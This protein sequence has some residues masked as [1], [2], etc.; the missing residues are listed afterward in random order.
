[1]SNSFS[2]SEPGRCESAEWIN[3]AADVCQ[4]AA[5]GNLEERLLHVHQTGNAQR[6]MLSINHLLDMTD[7]FVREATAT[8][9]HASQGKFF[10]RVLKTGMLGTFGRASESINEATAKMDGEHRKL[11]TAETD[12]E[13][14]SS[15]FQQA[16][17]SVADLE[18]STQKVIEG[19]KAIQSISS[20]TNLLALNSAIEAA[21]V[22]DA[23][24]GFAVVAG[25]V[26]SLANQTAQTSNQIQ[27]QIQEMATAAKST[28][29]LINS[30]WQRLQSTDSVQRKGS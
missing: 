15:D 13:R 3:R 25:E 9:E 2:P 30:I 22:G 7:A 23:G 6:L 1:M 12:R 29:K 20:K 26:K 16:I 17:A 10:R 27:I 11:Q 8:R 18:K 4:A 14:L 24:L 21:R 5:R 19:I 28:A